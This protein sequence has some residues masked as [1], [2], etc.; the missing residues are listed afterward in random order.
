MAPMSHEHNLAT[1]MLTI[2]QVA[3]RTGLRASAIRYDEAQGLLP[4]APRQAGK[5][6][7]ECGRAILEARS[8][9]PTKGA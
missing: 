5:R 2:G 8:K 9:R 1:M 7:Q 6:M 3:S 4:R